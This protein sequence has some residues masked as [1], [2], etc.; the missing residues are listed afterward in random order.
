MTS[1][2]LQA[3][4]RRELISDL[5]VS[6]VTGAA[7][8]AIAAETTATRHAFRVAEAKA[9]AIATAEAMFGDHFRKEAAALASTDDDPS[10]WGEEFVVDQLRACATLLCLLDTAGIGGR[11]AV[12]GRST[13][14]LA[15]FSALG[16]GRKQASDGGAWSAAIEQ[17]AGELL[18][19][20]ALYAPNGAVGLGIVNGP[21]SVILLPEQLQAAGLGP[22]AM[23]VA[24]EGL[25]LA[26]GLQRW[27]GWKLR[28]QIDR[29][30]DGLGMRPA[31]AWGQLVNELAATTAPPVSA[32]SIPDRY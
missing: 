12:E 27:L 8:D 30:W 9:V 10:R 5:A 2:N 20:A 7:A 22:W 28:F 32:G 3:Q 17:A 6:G 4:T 1:I 23:T 29:D 15:C 31:E 18:P 13:A 26:C 24:R 25:R 19:G 14:R 21:F 11:Q 16:K